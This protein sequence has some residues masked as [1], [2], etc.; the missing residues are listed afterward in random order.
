M[1]KVIAT[2][3][4]QADNLDI[5]LTLAKELVGTTVREEGCISYGM[6]QDVNNPGKLIMVE[7][8]ESRDALDKHLASTHFTTLVPQMGKHT[9]RETEISICNS[10]F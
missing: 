9:E 7:E 8:W 3:S 5:F 2:F 10:L 4:V 6:L 1:V